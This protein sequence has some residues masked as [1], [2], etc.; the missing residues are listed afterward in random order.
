MDR[1]KRR[2]RVTL[3]PSVGAQWREKMHPFFFKVA[4]LHKRIALLSKS[5]SPEGRL[6]AQRLAGEIPLELQQEAEK[7]HEEMKAAGTLR[8]SPWLSI[9]GVE[10]C[11]PGTVIS[12]GHSM[13]HWLCWFKYGRTVERLLREYES[14]S[15][16]AAKQLHGLSLEYD[17]WRFG[18]QD[19]NKLKFKADLDHFELMI[20]GLNLGIKE[21]TAEELADCFDELSPCGKQHYPENLRKLR[22]R[23]LKV[24]P[25]AL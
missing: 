21:L 13:F 25:P 3:G 7:L 4:D 15:L 14:G 17:K 16:R 6:E 5:E 9:L 2:S 22:A 23:I 12:E 11:P 10:G 18:K 24:F 1:K 20:G 8:H 19:P